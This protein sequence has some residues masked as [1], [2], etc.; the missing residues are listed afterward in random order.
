MA[1]AAGGTENFT[2]V[3]DWLRKCGG[4]GSTPEADDDAQQQGFSK[5]TVVP[6][7]VSQIPVL[8]DLRPTSREDCCGHA[9]SVHPTRLTEVAEHVNE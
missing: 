9:R 4:P 7:A 2:V 6:F 3:G 1:F 5:Y 8:A